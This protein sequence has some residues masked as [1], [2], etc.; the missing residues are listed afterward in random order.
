MQINRPQYSTVPLYKPIQPCYDVDWKPL[1]R[2][3]ILQAGPTLF[4]KNQIKLM[5][6]QCY[7]HEKKLLVVVA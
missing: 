7:T 3:K 5:F 4:S 1:K 2:L 6:W